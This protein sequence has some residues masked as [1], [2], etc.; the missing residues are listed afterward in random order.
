VLG[1]DSDSERHRY[2]SD[3]HYRLYYGRDNR[4]RVIT[5]QDF[6]YQED[7][8][9]SRLLSNAAFDTEKEA[10]DALRLLLL[11]AAAVLGILPQALILRQT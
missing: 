11:D 7:F 2:N 9:N 3:V 10:E 8:D 5:M 6:D 4:P 1:Y